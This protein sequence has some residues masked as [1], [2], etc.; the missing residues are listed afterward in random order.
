MENKMLDELAKKCVI[1]DIEMKRLHA[2]RNSKVTIIRGK[3]VDKKS[4]KSYLRTLMVMIGNEIITS[5]YADSVLFYCELKLFDK[6]NEQNNFFALEQKNKVCNLRLEQ[7]FSKQKIHFS[8]AEAE[9][10]CYM[11]TNSKLGL[12]MVR[13]LEEEFI[14]TLAELAVLLDDE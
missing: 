1:G 11:F 8:K 9:A 12:S 5:N 14:P 13:I 4:N 3:E 10:F 7:T 6:G 2:V